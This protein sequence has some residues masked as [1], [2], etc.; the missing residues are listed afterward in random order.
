MKFLSYLRARAGVLFAGLALTGLAVAASTAFPGFQAVIGALV[1]LSTDQPTIAM[2]GQT[3]SAQLG[4][5]N[6]GSFVA[7]GA[8]TGASTLTFANA[9]PN[10][11]ACGIKDLTT[12]ADS[13]NQTNATDGKTVV[14]F[15]GTV[16]SGD[17]FTYVCHAY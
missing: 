8:T 12:P 16:V 14:T 6:W 10:G 17:K 15:S 1:D 4:G 11:R 7:T 13:V 3:I 9:A 2:T 5:S